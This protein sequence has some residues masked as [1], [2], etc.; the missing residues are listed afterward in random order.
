MKN[1]RNQNGSSAARQRSLSAAIPGIESEHDLDASITNPVNNRHDSEATPSVTADA[2]RRSRRGAG[3]GVDLATESRTR[4]E[5]SDKMTRANSVLDP[6]TFYDDDGELMYHVC[7]YF[8]EDEHQGLIWG[9]PQGAKN[10]RYRR[11]KSWQWCAKEP[12]VREGRMGGDHRVCLWEDLEPI[13]ED[14]WDEEV[15]EMKWLSGF[16]TVRI[17]KRKLA[18]PMR[19][20]ITP[21]VG[22]GSRSEMGDADADVR[23]KRESKHPPLMPKEQREI[24]NEKVKLRQ[25][26]D[27]VPESD[28]WT[29]MIMDLRRNTQSGEIFMM[30]APW[31]TRD[32]VKFRLG[33]FGGGYL[34]KRWPTSKPWEFM[35]GAHFEVVPWEALI[36]RV[37]ARNDPRFCHEMMYGAETLNYEVF[38]REVGRESYN[39]DGVELNTEDRALWK[40]WKRQGSRKGLTDELKRQLEEERDKHE[41]RQRATF[42]KLFWTQELWD[43]WLERRRRIDLEPE[44]LEAEDRARE[45][46]ER[47]AKRKAESFLTLPKIEDAEDGDGHRHRHRHGDEDDE[48]EDEAFQPFLVKAI[49]EHISRHKDDLSFHHGQIITVVEAEDENWYVGEY[50]DA[51]GVKQ[52]GIFPRNRVKRYTTEYAME[53]DYQIDGLR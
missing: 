22:E 34:N 4:E 6:S 48:D 36:E 20:P 10:R 45:E 8:I 32:E 33:Q 2:P 43:T 1:L 38:G 23:E 46:A 15:K 44:E 16:E 39:L 53:V 41:E 50:T 18:T 17:D 51:K 37:E 19:K 13:R 42:A 31:W 27:L 24:E 5:S 49:W 3:T 47:K 14:W 35:L 9:V 26:K 29:A 7:P 21:I 40:A 11:P 52:E 25:G 12:S 28:T 30:V